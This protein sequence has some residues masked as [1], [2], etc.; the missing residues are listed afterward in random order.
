MI[1]DMLNQLKR[2][3]SGNSSSALSVAF[4]CEFVLLGIM[5]L[6]A[7][8]VDSTFSFVVFSVLGLLIMVTIAALV[9]KCINGRNQT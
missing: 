7:K 5:T 2:A 3:F 4:L 9:L 6:I 1:T 8:T